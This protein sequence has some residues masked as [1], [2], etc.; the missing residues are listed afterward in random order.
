M[1]SVRAFLALDA[2]R[3]LRAKA[4]YIRRSFLDFSRD[5]G[6]SENRT[7]RWVASENLHLTVQFIG[8]IPWT[9]V[10]EIALDFDRRLE[11]R[12]SGT[13]GVSLCG[14]DCFDRVLFMKMV[15]GEEPLKNLQSEFRRSLSGGSVEYDRRPFK[16]HLT[17]ARSKRSLRREPGREL[18]G[19]FLPELDFS[20]SAERLVLYESR[21]GPDGP[22]YLPIKE[23]YLSQ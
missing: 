13:F 8:D 10:G 14:F 23:F 17:L 4:D 15:E 11:K 9:E 16:G 6:L 18:L 20:F 1:K 22:T 21:L 19:N 2:P 3:Q 12:R 7:L 5:K